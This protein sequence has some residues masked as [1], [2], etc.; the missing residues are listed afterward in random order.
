M[1][2]ISVNERK[3]SQRPNKSPGVATS[4]AL[5]ELAIRPNNTHNSSTAP[6][7]GWGEY[8]Y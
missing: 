4:Q 6:S 3:E 7:G 1:K 5:N 8:Y 2:I